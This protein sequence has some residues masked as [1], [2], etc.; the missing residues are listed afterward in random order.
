MTRD[1]RTPSLPQGYGGAAIGMH[2]ALH[3]W[4]FRPRSALLGGLITLVFMGLYV[5]AYPWLLQFWERILD[6]GV[7]WL[8]LGVKVRH[9]PVVW[10]LG[11]E[12]SVDR[13]VLAGPMPVAPMWS[14][15]VQAVL[16]IVAWVLLK[17]LRE[18]WMPVAYALRLLLLLYLVSLGYFAWWA[19]SFPYRLADHTRD[20]FAFNVAVQCLAPL[21]LGLTLFPLVSDH[22]HRVGA[23]LVIQGYFALT[24]PF[25]MLAHTWLATHIGAVSL[26]LLYLAF[27]PVLDVL[28]MV[29]LFSWVATWF[30]SPDIDRDQD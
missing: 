14:L 29:A 3:N 15:V 24:L 8:H 1:T 26:P 21:V 20:I 17:R 13:L 10:A 12:L 25:K 6:A 5:L 19:D 23:C 18:A 9:W 27:G 7:T 22:L 4:T 16:A 11:S 2:R 28:L 30:T